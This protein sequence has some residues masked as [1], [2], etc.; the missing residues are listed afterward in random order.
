MSCHNLH[1]APT[2]AAHT[3]GTEKAIATHLEAEE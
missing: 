2:P 1:P 3:L